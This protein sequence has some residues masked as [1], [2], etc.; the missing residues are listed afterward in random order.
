[1]NSP[2]SK[3][4]DVSAAREGRSASGSHPPE[5][6]RIL[7][8]GAPRAGKTTLVSVIVRELQ[9]S[10]IVVAGFTTCELRERGGRVGFQVEAIGG[11]SAV[12]AHVAFTEGPRVGRY[13]VDVPAFEGIALPA[14]EQAGRA[15]GVA[16][17][18]ELGQMELCSS[19]FVQAVQHLFERDVPLV[20][21]VHAKAHP[22]TDALRRRPG[23]ELLTV[24]RAAHEE[25][26][27]RVT[28]RL[29]AA[30]GE[31]PSL[32]PREGSHPEP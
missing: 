21:T 16:V 24:T 1:V 19:A 15:G 6:P 14:L 23:V 3:T 27:A 11:D 10:G 4:P 26:L 13:R 31:A 28:G 2:H 32:Q 22:V 29:L 9:A 30:Q 18:D 5:V 12:T 8:T 25:L 7:L 20:A 17:I